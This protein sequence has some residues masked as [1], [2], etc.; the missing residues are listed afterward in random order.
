MVG[1]MAEKLCLSPGQKV[2]EIGGGSGYHAAVVAHIVGPEGHVYSVERIAS[3]AERARR[4][5]EEAGYSKTVTMV[6]GDGTL[7]LPEHAPYDRIFVAAASPGI[8][9]PLFEQLREG[10]KMLVPVGDVYLGQELVMVEKKNGRPVTTEH[11]GCVFVPLIGAH[12]F[13]R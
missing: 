10:G 11:G 12:G 2:L 4:S 8:P 6:V 1:I 7:G 9:P 3:L 5:L 13:R